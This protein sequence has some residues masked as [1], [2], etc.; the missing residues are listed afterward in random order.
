MAWKE[1]LIKG[2]RNSSFFFK[3]GPTSVEKKQEITKIKDD[4]GVWIDDPLGI[5]Q[6]FI[7]D[8]IERF[9]AAYK[10]PRTLPTLG[11]PAMI[12]QHDNEILTQLP[13]VEGIKKDVFEINPNKTPGPDGFNA[14]F[15]S[16]LPGPC[17]RGAY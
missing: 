1:W 7:T 16:T 3:R 4:V 15:F 8:Y 17:W 12:T 13:S 14:G 9:R 11:I 6:K 5:R 2:D 10:T